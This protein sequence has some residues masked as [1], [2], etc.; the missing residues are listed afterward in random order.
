M[1]LRPI[2]REPQDYMMN[3]Y[4]V[5][6]QICLGFNEQKSLQKTVLT[7]RRLKLD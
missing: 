5:K 1:L 3:P 4:R 7:Y 6:L 2:W